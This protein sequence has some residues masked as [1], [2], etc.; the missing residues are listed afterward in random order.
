MSDGK[1]VMN[2]FTDAGDGAVLSLEE[3]VRRVGDE[4]NVVSIIGGLVRRGLLVREKRAHYRLARPGEDPRADPLAGVPS[5]TLDDETAADIR[6]DERRRIAEK[7]ALAVADAVPREAIDYI[8]GF[9][10]GANFVAEY[11]LGE[12]I[13]APKPK[14]DLV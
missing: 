2:V 1:V 3:V 7:L 8:R 13:D 10:D 9:Q 14:V 6:A 5:S 4:S 11:V 12:S